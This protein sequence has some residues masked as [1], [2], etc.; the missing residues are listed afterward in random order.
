[1][2]I[3]LT[4]Y[5]T[6][7]RMPEPMQDV[8]VNGPRNPLVAHFAPR[9]GCW[10]LAETGNTL[11]FP[12][13]WWSPLP[14][15]DEIAAKL[16]RAEPSGEQDPF[17]LKSHQDLHRAARELAERIG[18]KGHIFSSCEVD[19][20]DNVPV[21]FYVEFHA[22]DKSCRVS[23]GRLGNTTDPQLVYA[24]FEQAMKDRF[25]PEQPI[26]AGLEAADGES[27]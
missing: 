8:I 14:E 5:R 1:M 22:S 4:I 19:D 2:Q 10:H 7:E 18:A 21:S 27:T 9:T 11:I 12:P 17:R 24:A 3:P 23:R 13:T 6:S 20:R 26:P 16:H 15:A 25:A